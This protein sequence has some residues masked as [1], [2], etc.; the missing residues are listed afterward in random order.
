MSRL[1]SLYYVDKYPDEVEEII[2]I[3]MSLPKKQLECWQDG[4]FKKLSLEECK[5]FYRKSMKQVLQ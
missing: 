3:D 2:V 1:Y 4:S 5:S